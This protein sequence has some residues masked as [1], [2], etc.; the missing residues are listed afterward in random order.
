TEVF[1][2]THGVTL[3]GLDQGMPFLI[4]KDPPEH[5]FHRKIAARLFTPRRI[6][7]L[8]PFVRDT[9]A[10]LLDRVLD[11]DTFDLAQEF[12]FRLPLDVISELIGIPGPLR[13]E[14]HELSDRTA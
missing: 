11:Q 3:E 9:A 5:T 7:Q 10:R 2:S 8:E 14:L 12:S 4:V 1:T 13:R 6:S